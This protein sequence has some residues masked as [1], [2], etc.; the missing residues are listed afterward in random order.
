MWDPSY[1]SRDWNTSP[2]L[3]AWSLNHWTTREVPCVLFLE[4]GF[5]EIITASFPHSFPRILLFGED[6]ATRSCVFF[7]GCSSPA[8]S[9]RKFALI[10]FPRWSRR[11]HKGL[12]DGVMRLGHTSDQLPG[13]MQPKAGRRQHH[14]RARKRSPFPS[15]ASCRALCWQRLILHLLHRRSA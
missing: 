14:P 8:A 2:S 12:D 1:P 5:L 11:V 13:A 9:R 7:I 3:E 15:H 4:G 10:I 6:S